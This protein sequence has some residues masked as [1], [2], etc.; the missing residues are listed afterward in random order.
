MNVRRS[1][2][3]MGTTYPPMHGQ[4]CSGCGQVVAKLARYGLCSICAYLREENDR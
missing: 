3:E 4:Q 2:E 1:P